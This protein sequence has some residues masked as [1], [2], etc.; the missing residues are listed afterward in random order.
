MCHS[1]DRFWNQGGLMGDRVRHSVIWMG[2][3]LSLGFVGSLVA[4]A[5][6]PVP[7]PADVVRIAEKNALLAVIYVLA[8]LVA[9]CV[10]VAWNMYK[11]MVAQHEKSLA[12]YDKLIVI[13][14][15]QAA[16]DARMAEVLNSRP[17][18]LA[19]P[20]PKNPHALEA[21]HAG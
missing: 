10:Y 8:L 13:M 4:Y 19:P 20:Q 18:I 2:L 3:P 9:G 17:C 12:Q 14:E 5:Q 16:A 21:P 11:A 15:K 7:D 1:L 6:V